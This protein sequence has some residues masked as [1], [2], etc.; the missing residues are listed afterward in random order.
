MLDMNRQRL[1]IDNHHTVYILGAG[2]SAARGLPVIKEFMTALRDAHPWLMSHDRVREAES[3]EAVLQYRLDSAAA[4]YRIPIDL[5]NIEELFSLSD[6]GRAG[7]SKHIRIAIAATLDFRLSTNEAP[8]TSF[9]MS[10]IRSIPEAWVK[11]ST[12]GVDARVPMYD[13]IVHSM[14]GTWSDAEATSA[15]ITFNYDCILDKSLRNLGHEVDY[16]L[17]A[18]THGDAV[19]VLKLHGSVNWIRTKGKTPSFQVLEDYRVAAEAKEVPEL[20]PPTWRKLFAK[21][22]V[23]IWGRALQELERATRIIVIGFSMPE[24]DLHFKYLLASGLRKN[25]ALREIVFVDPAEKRMMKR[26]EE[27]F[28]DVHRRPPVRVIASSVSQFIG[29]GTLPQTISSIGR[30]IPD[31]ISRLQHSVY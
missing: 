11:G 29:A 21:E 19:R 23:P 15:F 4:A 30:R 24:T 17:H 5:E 3:V 22:L 9:Q 28:G 6:T 20:V 8:T 26:V 31:H 1:R 13:F 14:I 2:F 27:L 7:L 10:D 16:G 25:V 18:K 12:N